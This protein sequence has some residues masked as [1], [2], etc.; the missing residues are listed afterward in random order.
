MANINQNHTFLGYIIVLLALFVLVFFTKNVFGDLQQNLD[1]QDQ[2][3]AKL[4][5][6]ETELSQLNTIKKDFSDNSSEASS[7]ISKFTKP[8]DDQ[9]IIDHIYDY[10]SKVN[11]NGTAIALRWVSFSEGTVWDLWFKEATID[12]SARFG[13]EQ[14]LINMISYFIDPDANYTFFIDA[15]SYP[16]IWKSTS[17][18]A[19]IPLKLFYK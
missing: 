14:T 8:F 13:S 19:S 12:V 18:Q 11:A 6:N 10:V 1:L 7:Q 15:L 2:K 9:A 3:N 4:Q 5:Q 17:F 16:A